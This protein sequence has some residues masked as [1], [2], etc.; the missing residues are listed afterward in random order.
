MHDLRAGVVIQAQRPRFDNHQSNRAAARRE[1]RVALEKAGIAAGETVNLDAE[2]LDAATAEGIS[3]D[4]SGDPATIVP[5][6]DYLRDRVA[7][8]AEPPA[9]A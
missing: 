3:W 1:L 8:L 7:L 2:P 5:L 9:G 4:G 6:A